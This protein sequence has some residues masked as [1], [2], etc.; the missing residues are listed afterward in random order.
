MHCL[1]QMFHLAYWIE[2]N[3]CWRQNRF[4]SPCRSSAE[5]I[6]HSRSL[7]DW[8]SETNS[9]SRARAWKLYNNLNQN[10]L[11]VLGQRLRFVT[12]VWF[13]TIQFEE[14]QHGWNFR[15]SCPCGWTTEEWK[16]GEHFNSFLY[17]SCTVVFFSHG[18]LSIY[19]IQAE[20]DLDPL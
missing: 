5:T 12:S 16:W 10:L 18:R 19:F 11:Y 1:N 6:F 4:C 8:I 13:W 14:L 2:H 9:L 3:K 15:E 20:S 17:S 7:N